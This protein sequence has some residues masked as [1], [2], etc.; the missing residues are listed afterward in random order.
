ML[1]PGHPK[2]WYSNLEKYLSTDR[3]LR[4]LGD[5]VSK[6]LI[7]MCNVGDD[8]NYMVQAGQHLKGDK[9]RSERLKSVFCQVKALK[10]M[11]G[12]SGFSNYLLKKILAGDEFVKIE[13][14]TSGDNLLLFKVL[15]HQSI[16]NYF[17]GHIDFVKYEAYSSKHVIPLNK[18]VMTS[19]DLSRFDSTGTWYNGDQI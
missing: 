5:D 1:E 4:E 14:E 7:K 16:K 19:E 9:F 3:V 10:Q 17:S 8:K 11:L 15:T 13:E 18:R 2:E 6:I 12:V